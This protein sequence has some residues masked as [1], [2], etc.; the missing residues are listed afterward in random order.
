MEGRRHEPTVPGCHGSGAHCGPPRGGSGVAA[1]LPPGHAPRPQSGPAGAGRPPGRRGGALMST[2]ERGPGGTEH[3]TSTPRTPVAV[4]TWL[5]EWAVAVR[6]G[7][8]NQLVVGRHTG[9]RC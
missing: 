4:W 9:A 7:P 5:G 2:V 8:A 3:V 6:L 1:G